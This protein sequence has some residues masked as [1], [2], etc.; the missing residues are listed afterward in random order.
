MVQY[1]DC[2]TI[3]LLGPCL[4]LQELETRVVQYLDRG[5]N[6]EAD[7]LNNLNSVLPQEA[8]RGIDCFGFA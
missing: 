8:S 4:S 3:C 1:L 6:V 5:T 2:G 7:V